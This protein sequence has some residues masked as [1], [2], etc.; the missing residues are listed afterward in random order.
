MTT[1]AQLR[2]A[3]MA[4]PEVAEGT[5]FG[6][7]AFEVAGKGFVSVTEDDAVQLAMTEADVGRTLET[8]A[9]ARPITRS[10]KLIGVSVPLGEVNGMVLNALVE[11][12]WRAKAPKVLVRQREAA[13]RGEAPSG[14]DALPSTIGKPATRA[15]LAAGITTLAA[16]VARSDEELLALHGVGPKAV[17]LLRE[18]AADG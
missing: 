17:R 6:M 8:V 4:L 3:A 5:H 13:V 15:L 18:A 7:L 10:G 16:A 1:L 2:K 9:T 12:S 11:R 14:P